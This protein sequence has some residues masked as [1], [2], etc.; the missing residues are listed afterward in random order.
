M[1]DIDKTNN[2]SKVPPRLNRLM[3]TAAILGAFL[4]MLV[5]LFGIL[6]WFLG[7]VQTHTIPL[8]V[9]VRDINWRSALDLVIE[10]L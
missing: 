7:S 3:Q 5:S 2:L 10:N 1:S 9:I 4:G 6:A 8:V